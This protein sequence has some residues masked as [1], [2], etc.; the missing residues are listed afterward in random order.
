M[1]RSITIDDEVYKTLENIARPFV[2]TP[3]S[4]LRRVLGLA[5]TGDDPTLAPPISENRSSKKRGKRQSTRHT[6]LPKG[7]LL[8]ETEYELP[9]LRA[10]AARGEAAPAAEVIEDVGRELSKRF[11]EAEYT[12]N[13]SGLVRWKNRAQFARLNLVKTGELDRY[14][15]RGTWRITEAGRARLARESKG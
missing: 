7:S 1:P 3:N 12:I 10:I 9:I 8:P 6:R 13:D 14:A 11:K 4:V 5:E 2:D 15:P